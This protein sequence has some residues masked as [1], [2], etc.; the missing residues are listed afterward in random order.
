LARD[1]FDKGREGEGEKGGEEELE[2]EEDDEE[3]EEA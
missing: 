2:E 3:E 1:S